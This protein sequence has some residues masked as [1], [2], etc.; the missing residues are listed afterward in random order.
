MKPITDFITRSIEHP[1]TPM[2]SIAMRSTSTQAVGQ[3][4]RAP[5]AA[6]ARFQRSFARWLLLGILLLASSGCVVPLEGIIRAQD[7]LNTERA[8]IAA[9]PEFGAPGTVIAVAGA[10]WRPTDIITVKLASALDPMALEESVTVATVGPD[11]TFTA[12]FTFTEEARWRVFPIVYI[13]AESAQT[14]VRAHAT[15]QLLTNEPTSTP[16]V[17]QTAATGPT[18]TWTPLVRVTSATATPVPPVTLTQ[19]ATT[20]PMPSFTPSATPMRAT[21]TRATATPIVVGP[22]QVSVTSGGLNVRSGPNY[23]Y[24]IVRAVSR[25]TVLTVLAENPGNGWI[26]VRLADGAVGWVNGE[27][28]TYRGQAPTAVPTASVVPQ[29]TPTFTSTPAQGPIGANDWRGEYFANRYLAGAPVLVRGDSVLDFNWGTGSPAAGLPNNDF[30]VRWSRSPY[31]E[32]GRYRFYVRVDDGARLYVDDALIL[33]RWQDGS[34]REFTVERSLGSGWHNLRLEYYEHTQNARIAIWW[35]RIGNIDDD[36]DDKDDDDDFPQWKGA[37]Y[38]NN[39]LDGDPRFRRNDREIDFNWG[40]DSPDSRIPDDNFSVRWSRRVDFDRGRYRFEVRA[41]DGI[42]VYIDGNRV[43]N[44][45]HENDFDDGYTF[46]FD[47]DHSHDLVVEYYERRGGARVYVDWD[48]IGDIVTATA[49]PIP[50]ATPTAT[51]TA[52]TG[53]T[54]LPTATS[55]PIVPTATATAT[56]TPSITPTVIQP[57]ANVQPATGGPGSQVTINGGGFPANALVNVHLGALIGVQSSASDPVSYVSTTTDRTGSYSVVLALPATWPDGSPIASGELLILVATDDF[58]AQATTQLAYTAVAP[59][60]TATA[61]ATATPAATA[62]GT[63][64]ATATAT[65]TA[66]PTATAEATATPVPQPFVTV[67]PTAVRPG[68]LVRV[69]GGGFPADTQLGLYLGVFDGEIS[70]NDAAVTFASTLTDGEGNY[71]MSFVMPDDT[72]SGVL[73]ATGK[74]AIVVATDN[75]MLQAAAVLDFTADEP[76]ATPVAAAGQNGN[77]ANGTVPPTESSTT[78]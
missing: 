58:G 1:A 31:F 52:T 50:T 15:F 11:G 53:A 74:I 10:G 67:E 40:D 43:L 51:A 44:E 29:A 4:P 16:T 2:R 18:A 62:T 9:A 8:A 56:A 26:Q 20:A 60:A 68:T 59:T 41:D 72:P 35:E 64:P 5:G 17:T 42:R 69:T 73:L 75:M 12:S 76:T 55:T 49:T 71:L 23:F 39:D 77:D 14:Q 27:Y 54:D 37:Y 7:A 45:W 66:L 70:P 28:T 47:L 63:L 19:R 61:T 6:L 3:T 46:E 65:A 30:S 78:E 38:T 25:G 22:Q 13:V 24:A 33:D 21:A 57:S 36:D 32:S 48:R 34:E